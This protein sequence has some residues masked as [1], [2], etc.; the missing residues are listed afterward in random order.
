[1]NTLDAALQLAIAYP[2]GLAAMALR[3]GKPESTLRKEL[4]GVDGYKL[5]ALTL[6]TMTMLAVSVNQHNALVAASVSASN[7]GHMLLPLPDL[8]RFADGADVM[9]DLAATAKEFADLC[10]E[11]S[12][13][14]KDGR[15]TDNELK[16]VDRETGELIVSLHRMRERL[17]HMNAAQ[18]AR[19]R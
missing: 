10:H 4:T 12:K 11:V 2:G 3:L 16:R 19:Q 18:K 5:G 14:I 6:E 15:I 1:M 9:L 7:F 17:A 8:D 13:D